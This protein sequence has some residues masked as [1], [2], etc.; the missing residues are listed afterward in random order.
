LSNEFSFDYVPQEK[1]ALLHASNARQIFYGGAAGGGKSHALRWDLITW[2]F[3]APGIQCYIFRRTYPELEDNHIKFIKSEIPPALGEY[4]ES[5]KCMEFKNGSKIFFCYCERDADVRKYL[6]AEM[7]VVALD[8]ASQMTPSQIN[9]I[10]TRNRL[11][12]FRAPEDLRHA[13]PRFMMGSNPGGPAHSYLKTT[14]IDA[15]PPMEAFFDESMKDPTNPDD[16]GWLSVFIPAK[17]ADNE[18]IDKGYAASFSGLPPELARAYRDGDWDAVVGQALQSLSRERHMLRQF[19]IPRHWTRF[20]CIDWGTA[21]PFSV[22]W[23]AVSDGLLLESKRDGWSRYIPEGALVRYAEWYGCATDDNGRFLGN[24]GL[25]LDATAVA[26]GILAREADRSEPPIDYRVGDSQM[27]AQSDGPSVAERMV[28][29]DARLAMRKS[30]KDRKHNFSEILARLAGNPDLMHDG[31]ENDE[32]DLFITENCVHF[33]RT[34][35]ILTLD[36]NDPDKGP[37]QRLEDHVYDE[38]AYACRS[39]PY[40]NTERTRFDTEHASAIAAA[41]GHSGDPYATA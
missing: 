32:P 8:E 4:S 6:G 20:S 11:G 31:E 22:G 16:K 15:A 40:V 30:E 25:R 1:Q 41:R 3:R 27:W 21:K 13:L 24:Q 5:R 7:H 28:E 14:F 29:V 33:W 34:V 17:I 10:K 38:V 18:Y 36:E 9:F 23:Y 35:P 39:R 19:P 26:R 12:G 2:C 37:D